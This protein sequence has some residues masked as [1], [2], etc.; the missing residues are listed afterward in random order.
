MN[1][2]LESLYSIFLSPRMCFV[3]QNDFFIVTTHSHKLRSGAKNNYFDDNN[4]YVG[5]KIL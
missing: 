4:I 2:L 3:A 5:D 1:K